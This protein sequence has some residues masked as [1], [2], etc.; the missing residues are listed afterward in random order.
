MV[1]KT[2]TA[3][4]ATMDCSTMT[5]EECMAKCDSM[6]C[7]DEERAVCMAQYDENGKFVGGKKACCTDKSKTT[8]NKN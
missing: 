6:Q 7:S 2:A 1:S 8:T 3:E 4:S 5:K